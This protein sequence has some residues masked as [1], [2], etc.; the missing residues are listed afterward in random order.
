MEINYRVRYIRSVGQGID[1]KLPDKLV[2]QFVIFQI[3]F[4]LY[5]ISCTVITLRCHVI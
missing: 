3:S 1:K 2:S 4:D 5:L